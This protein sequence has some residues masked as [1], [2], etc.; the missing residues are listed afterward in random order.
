MK[1]TDQ[2]GHEIILKQQPKR[3]ISLVPSQTELLAD[4]GLGEEVVGI[5]KFCVH[6][7]DWFRKKKRVGG[8]KN[9]N[10]NA[11]R[12]LNP[13][14]IIANKEENERGQVEELSRTYPVWVSDVRNLDHA[15]DMVERVGELTGKT[16]KA[17][18]ITRKICHKFDTTLIPPRPR[19]ALYF[20]WKEPLMTVNADTFIHDMMQ[21]SG[22]NNLAAGM[23]A[24]Y[25]VLTVEQ[26]RQLNP[27][28]VLLSSEPYP[29]KEKHIKAFQSWVPAARIMLIDGEAFSWYGS[30]LLRGVQKLIEYSGILL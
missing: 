30:G 3:I 6:P 5:T 10:L 29:F 28:F 7:E 9:V 13:D 15:I 20:I 24:R 22:F 14:L 27:E 8:T 25:P 18:E 12:K 23:P 11:I 16:E 4:L 2:L 26:L 17:L 19:R 21:R 1:F